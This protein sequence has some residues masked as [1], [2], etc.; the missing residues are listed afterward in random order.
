LNP[1]D[2]DSA[3]GPLHHVNVGSVTDVSEVRAAIIFRVEVDPEDQH[4]E[5]IT[6]NA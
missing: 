2:V 4:Q 5:C 6:V 3:V 1:V